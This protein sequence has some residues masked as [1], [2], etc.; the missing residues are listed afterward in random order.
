MF[1]SFTTRSHF[2]ISFS[3]KASSQ[4]IKVKLEETLVPNAEVRVD[5]VGQDLREDDT[6]V[7]TDALPKRPAFASGSATTLAS[8]VAS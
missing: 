3:M 2:F 5:L 4:A 7:Q 6:G 8:C 1:P